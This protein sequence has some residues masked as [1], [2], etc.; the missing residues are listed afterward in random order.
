LTITTHPARVIL[1]HRSRLTKEYKTG[2][3]DVMKFGAVGYVDAKSR[4]A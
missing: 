2:F 4:V 3:L 1:V